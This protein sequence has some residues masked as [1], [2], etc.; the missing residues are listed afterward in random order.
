M[1]ITYVQIESWI[2]SY[3]WVLFRISAFVTAAPVLG[4]RTIPVSAKLG[5]S[6]ILTILIVPMIPAPTPIELFSLASA[7]MTLNQIII[8]IAMGFAFQL[9]FTMFIIGGQ[10]I[11]YQ[12]GLGFAQMVDPQSGTQVPV[13]SQFYIVTITLL[14][15]AL[16]GHIA[17]I[18]LLVESF[19]ILP[20]QADPLSRNG[21]WHLADWSK[22][23]FSGGLTIAIPAIAS[24]LVINFT[25][26]VVTRSAPQFNIFSIGFPVTIV[27]GFFVIMFTL[28]T[29]LPHFSIQFAAV[30]DLIRLMLGQ[31]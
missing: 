11:A 17:M 21:F 9:I 29:V 12:M 8:G 6:L 15:F 5:F 28:S 20:I 4:S 18:E 30:I 26:A 7:L 22:H 16:N 2:G 13:I 27:M 14:F 31:F 24:I 23:M 25:F 19:R 10:I 3:L 1:S